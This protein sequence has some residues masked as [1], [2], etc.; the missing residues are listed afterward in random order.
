M[1]HSDSEISVGGESPGKKFSPD[2]PQVQTEGF[3]KQTRY[4]KLGKVD[5][6]YMEGDLPPRGKLLPRNP[7]HRFGKTRVRQRAQKP[8]PIYAKKKKHSSVEGAGHS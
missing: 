4:P 2:T 5:L 6:E 1:G 8:C 3:W 7:R